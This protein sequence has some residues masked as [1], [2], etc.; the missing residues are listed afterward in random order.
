MP[1]RGH[2]LRAAA[3]ERDL[4]R[5][6]D[7]TLEP[8]R[9]DRVE[10]LVACSSELQGQLAEQHVAIA[11]TRA[12]VERERAPLA[13]RLHG[14]PL[15]QPPRRRRP[16]LGAG[17]VGAVGALIWLLF[18]LGGSQVTLT[19]AQAAAVAARPAVVAVAEPR[20]DGVTLPHL[21]SGGLPFPYWEDHFEWRAAGARTDRLRGRTLTTVFYRRGGRQV[22]YTIVP[23]GRLPAMSGARMMVRAGTVVMS[24]SSGGELIVTW[25]R[26]GHTC[27]LSGHGVSL[28]ALL[29]LAVWRGH[30][31][32]PF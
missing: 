28:E 10:R 15:A 8:S 19:V 17:L 30:G 5:L 7:G 4:A 29:K 24:S 1:G 6:A 27:V 31:R 3:I 18:A 14:R 12:I 21:R 2:H 26:R 13:L 20:D 23:G 11:A 32:I 25:L 16:V 9:R 22:A